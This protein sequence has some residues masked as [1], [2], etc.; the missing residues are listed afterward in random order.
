MKRKLNL[1]V[2]QQ[3]KN[4]VSRNIYT[5]IKISPVYGWFVHDKGKSSSWSHI[6]HFKVRKKDK[7]VRP[8]KTG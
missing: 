3:V 8:R 1:F 5:I 2:G 4:R 7:H 6:D